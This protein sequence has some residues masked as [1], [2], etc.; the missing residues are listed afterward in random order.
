MAPSNLR[1]TA[2]ALTGAALMAGCAATAAPPAVVGSS[3][4]AAASQTLGVTHYALGQRP[5][6]PELAGT[7]LDG[8]SL[9]V[10]SLRGQVVVLN[11]WA[12][13]CEPCRTES[14]AL[15]RVAKQ[16][17]A[18][19]VR[20]VGLDEQDR[21]DPARA[22][23]ASA[24]ATYPELVDAD[25]AL[26]GSLRL[27]PPSAV[28]STLVLDRAGRVAARVI[29]AGDGTTLDALVRALAAEQVPSALS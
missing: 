9:E 12:S 28:P 23:A 3:A 15:A 25:G 22:F 18:L 4:P 11:A 10:K 29:G 14:P 19:G 2:A 5:Q 13:Y 6:I 7:T 20:F 1:R 24:G 27:V 21:A 8:T 16:T 26:L 17:A